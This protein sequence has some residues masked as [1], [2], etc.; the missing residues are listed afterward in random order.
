MKRMLK[1]FQRCIWHEGAQ[2][3]VS[4]H[5]IIVTAPLEPLHVDYMGVEMTTGLNKMLK[6]VNVLVFQDH[7]TKHVMT[8]DT[9]YHTTKTVAKF[10]YQGYILSF[11]ALA[12]LLSDQG[13]NFASNIIFGVV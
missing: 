12:N 4:L 5:L 11:G 10:L 6:V 9:L 2:S 7:F 3:K 1:K 8:Y 13:P